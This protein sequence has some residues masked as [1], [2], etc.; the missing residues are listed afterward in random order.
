[1][2]RTQMQAVDGA[3]LERRECGV[4]LL[5]YRNCVTGGWRSGNEITQGQRVHTPRRSGELQ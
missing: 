4:R 1:L 5:P 2:P 3:H